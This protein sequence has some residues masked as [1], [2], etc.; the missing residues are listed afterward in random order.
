MRVRVYGPTWNGFVKHTL[1]ALY[2]SLAFHYFL[3]RL[4]NSKFE[5]LRR[6]APYRISIHL[7]SALNFIGGRNR[8][9][10]SGL[11]LDAQHGSL[12][13]SLCLRR[14]SAP[15]RSF[16]G[17]R[18]ATHVPLALRPSTTPA[19][20]GSFHAGFTRWNT[21]FHE[22]FTIQ[23]TQSEKEIRIKCKTQSSYP[24]IYVEKMKEQFNGNCELKRIKDTSLLPQEEKSEEVGK[25]IIDCLEQYYVSPTAY[26]IICVCLFYLPKSSRIIYSVVFTKVSV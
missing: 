12:Q 16:G 23:G 4:A 6:T 22:L 3:I 25:K 5:P 14:S 26:K 9:L 18:S 20:T 8:I 7:T 21:H 2:T 24:L 15:S 10:Q 19:L 1:T 17:A 13:T 11:I